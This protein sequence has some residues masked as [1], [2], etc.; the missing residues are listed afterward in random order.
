MTSAAETRRRASACYRDA[1]DLG[2]RLDPTAAALPSQE[3]ERDA[4][5]IA[6]V[7]AA[8]AE[9]GKALRLAAQG[10]ALTFLDR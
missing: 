3:D 7:L 8:A 9:L 4:A 5:T 2:A 6:D 10:L 1:R